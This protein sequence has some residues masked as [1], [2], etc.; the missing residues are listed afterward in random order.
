LVFCH[1][2]VYI[3]ILPAFGMISQVIS[4]FSNKAVFGR[5]GMIYAMCGIGFLAF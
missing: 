4:Q 2:E 5:I 3:L 1:P